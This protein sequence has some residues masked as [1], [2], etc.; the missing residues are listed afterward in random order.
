M[1]TKLIGLLWILIGLWWLI[2]PQAI[3]GFFKK[4]VRKRRF[5]LFISFLVLFGSFALGL[6]FKADT[7]WL[8]VLVVVGFIAIFKIFLSVSQ[9][10]SNKLYDYLSKI[11]QKYFRIFACLIIILGIIFLKVL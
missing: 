9:K 7:L 8:K 11:P 1:I 10:A 2:R 3:Q 4:K 5:K 6:F